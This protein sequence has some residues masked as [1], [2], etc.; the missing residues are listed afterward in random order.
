MKKDKYLQIFNYL[1]EFSK[2]RSKA[3]R[4]IDVQETQYP[5]K[6]W[7]NEILEDESFDNVIRPNFNEDNDHWLR[8]VKPKEPLEPQFPKLSEN[9]EKWVDKSSLLEDTC[10]PK[11]KSTLKVNGETLSIESFPEVKKELNEYVK[12]QWQKDLLRYRNKLAEGFGDND[13]LLNPESREASSRIEFPKLSESLEMWIDKPSLLKDTCTPKLKRTLLVNGEQVTIESYPGVRREFD[14]YITKKWKKDLALYREKLDEYKVESARFNKLNDIY[15]RLFRI[16][17]KAQQFGEEYEL[18]IGVGLLNFKENDETPRI[19]RHVLTQRVEITFEYSDKDS[20]IVVSPNLESAP[21]IESDSILDLITQ[22]DPNN[23]IEAER[24]AERFI[25]DQ[26]IETIFNNT[27][28]ILQIFAERISPDG[29]YKDAIGKPTHTPAKPTITFSPALL[30]RKR[31]TQSFTALYEKILENIESSDEQLEIPVINDLIGLPSYQDGNEG[32]STSSNEFSRGT[33][34]DPI[35]FPKEFNEEQLEIIDR[36]RRHNKVLVQGPPGTGKSH[37]IANLICHLLANGKKV[38]VTASTTRA[39]EVLKDKL[40]NEFQNLV[41]NLLSGDSSSLKGLEA[42]VN[43]INDE[44]AKADLTLYKSEIERLDSELKGVRESIAI[45]T[46][47][48]LNVRE[49]STRTQHFSEKYRGTLTSVAKTLEEDT[50]VFEWYKDTFGSPDHED[51]LI[52]LSDWIRLCDKYKGVETSELEYEIPDVNKL[53]TV[54]ELKEYADLSN[55]LTA[56]SNTNSIQT[57]KITS[58][59]FDKLQ[60]R[61]QDLLTLS[62]QVDKFQID[63]TEKVIASFLQGRNQEWF[64]LLNQ[65]KTVLDRLSIEDLRRFDLDIDITYPSDKGIKQ[66]KNDAQ[67][68]YD[69][70]KSGN[71]LAGLSFTIRKA[72]LPKEI[73]ERL[74]FIEEVRV[75]GSPCDTT[76]EYA[77][78]LQD[79]IFQQDF[80]ELTRIWKIDAPSKDSRQDKFLFFRRIHNEV[81]ELLDLIHRANAIKAT[82]E[83]IS[84]LTVKILDKDWINKTIEEVIQGSILKNISKYQESVRIS[85]AYL[86]RRDFHP[87]K[88]HIIQL[89]DS[90]NYYSY[91][92]LLSVLSKIKSDKDNYLEFKRLTSELTYKIPNIIQAVHSGTFTLSDI[93]KLKDAILFRHAEYQL[94]MLMD[95]NQENTLI[96]QLRELEQR[97][98]NLLA[99]LASKKAWYLLVERLQ[100]NHF[101]RQHLEAWV[102]AVKRIGKTGKGKRAIKFRKTAQQEMEYCKNSVPCWIM[103]LYK[104]AETIQPKQEMYDYIIV[105]EASQLGPDALFLLYISKNIIIVGDD[106]QTSPEYVGVDANA[107]TP[108]IRR[109]LHGIPFADYYGTEFSF[110][111]HA[112]LFCKGLTVLREH[113][114]CMPEIIEFSN[115]HFYA[116][117]GKGLYPL[118]QYSEERLPPLVTEFCPEGHIEGS[119]AKIINEPEAKRIVETI[120]DL[121]K[122]RRYSGKTMGIITLQGDQQ[123]SPIETLLLKKI[124]EK[125]FHDRKIVCGNSSSFQGDE[126]DIIFLS[127]VT[128]HN[129]RRSPLSKVEDERRFNVAVSRA[130]EQIWLFHSV[131]LEDLSNTND[132]RYKLLDHFKNYNSQQPIYTQKIERRLGTQPEPFDSWFEV[133][134][135]NDMVSR[136]LRVTPQYEVAKG[137]YRIDMVAHLPNGRKIAIECDGD[138]WHGPEQ[139]TNDL[140]RQKVL[141]RCGWQFFRVRGYEYYTNREKALDPFWQMLKRYEERDEE[142]K[143][144]AASQLSI[145]LAEES[146]PILE[147]LSEPFNIPE[148][149]A[150]A[151]IIE[152]IEKEVEQVAPISDSEPISSPN[153]ETG[154]YLVRYFNLFKSGVYILTDGEPIAADY[155][156]PIH[157]FKRNGYLLQCYKSGHI[158]KVDLKVILGKKSGKEYINGF[159][160]HGEIVHLEAIEFDQII[161]LVFKR[162]GKTMFKAHLTKNIPKQGQLNFL[163]YK[164]IYGNFEKVQY[165]IIPFDRYSDISRLVYNSFF[166]NGEPIDNGA[167]SNEFAAISNLLDSHQ[168]IFAKEEDLAEKVSDGSIVKLNDTVKLKM[169]VGKR[170]FT[171][172]LVDNI[173]EKRILVN[174]VQLI[175]IEDS[176]AQS[177]LGK[178]VGDV[179]KAANT[180]FLVEIIEIT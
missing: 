146:K 152:T 80:D 172:K 71:S 166:T 22:F 94:E 56:F 49:K 161:G 59:D 149:T 102:M 164:V 113:F 119:G 132:L 176:L 104:V 147:Q 136:N 171:V 61:L 64:L 96:Q 170:E 78:V 109:H 114:R 19:F 155:V 60:Q 55:R 1:K 175:H 73:K 13:K 58:S 40:P 123:G 157:H 99:K 21:Q 174:D 5:E 87:I 128:A 108:H 127:L 41:V 85:K 81:E 76:E 156:V 137:R 117:D 44:L 138:Q 151:V 63:F 153:P 101:L 178:K 74:Y 148:E 18:I 11:L 37:T 173:S 115:R 47:T 125:E 52:N 92:E 107:M 88:E 20:K 167:Y 53:L 179:V 165:E 95:V 118:K 38:L 33:Q 31:N 30:L 35:F 12:G 130:K 32:Y 111:D 14:E 70:L 103:P 112:K 67:I 9:L 110:F 50:T 84:N 57:R 91:E 75:N 162:S 163:G 139:F 120:A 90:L 82:I 105:D 4:D 62:N 54:H 27:H 83:G 97:E 10:T 25:K 24:S 39:L 34:A 77:T 116:P 72:F 140:M 7:L 124:G 145:S 169:G 100:Q 29:S 98:R 51:L 23:I 180:E 129:H 134:V 26:G 150:P 28:D 68:L 177:I 122:N 42:S 93:P 65:S 3:I 159:N 126:R 36:A 121:V 144:K 46:N 135:Y 69:Y 15:K 89:Y 6:L 106:K 79:V 43:A 8:I 86:D 133:D 158:N 141:E 143:I 168:A 142:E 131:Q 160:L 2:L 154:Y 17:N 16:F 66:I 45:T 48:L